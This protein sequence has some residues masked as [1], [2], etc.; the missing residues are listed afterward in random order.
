MAVNALLGV[1][2]WST[3]G[4][5][6]IFLHEHMNQPLAVFLISGGAAGG[7]QAVVAAPT[8]SVRLR[9]E[10]GAHNGRSAAWK[11]VFIETHTDQVLSRENL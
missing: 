7:I 8:E 3:Y 5:T 10:N 4:E 6:S 11:D 1:V 9:I 2:L